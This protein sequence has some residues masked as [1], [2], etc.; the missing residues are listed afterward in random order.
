M[1][2]L[3]VGALAV[4]LA[5]GLMLV[6][7]PVLV[8]KFVVLDKVDEVTK[9]A[10]FEN[11]P[12]SPTDI[13]AGESLYKEANFQQALDALTEEAGGKPELL[14]VGVLPY[15]AEFQIKQGDSAVGYR[16]Y[17]KNGDIGE[18]QVKIVGGGSIEGK[19]FAF[20]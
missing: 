17:A 14:K 20:G 16:Y 18:F 1:A 10:G 9:S 6:L 12:A 2:K 19:Q 11:I 8:V 7:V 3:Y 13:S 5:L 4:R 15:M